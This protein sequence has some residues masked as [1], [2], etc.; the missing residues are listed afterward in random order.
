MTRC[1]SK[2][3]TPSCEARRHYWH[4]TAVRQAGRR[5]CLQ[6]NADDLSVCVS[7]TLLHSEACST[8]RNL[9]FLSGSIMNVVDCSSGPVPLSHDAL[10]SSNPHARVPV[11][12]KP[13]SYL[14]LDRAPCRLHPRPVPTS[15]QL[16][17]GTRPC[18]PSSHRQER[19]G[20]HLRMGPRRLE[21]A[22]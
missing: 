6:R 16:T 7:A 4:P 5:A 3:Y 18:R 22:T 2:P 21:F 14:T 8:Y 17:L 10:A 1:E 9:C 12:T 19:D 20:E 15:S 13:C 11:A